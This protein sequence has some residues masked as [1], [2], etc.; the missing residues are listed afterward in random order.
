MDL[1]DISEIRRRLIGRRLTTNLVTGR[2]KLPPTSKGKWGL[3]NELLLGLKN[4]SSHTPD[5]GK[6]GE[7]KTIVLDRTGRFRES[8]KVC[9]TTQDPLEKLANTVLVVARDLNDSSELAQREVRNVSVIRLKPSKNVLAQL[10]YDC[11]VLVKIG[12]AH[13]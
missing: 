2:F 3:C 6:A 12:R 4:N 9:L 11:E 13:V 5:L 8:M 10:K 1:S 7:L